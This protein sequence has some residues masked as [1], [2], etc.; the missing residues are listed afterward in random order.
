MT[1]FTVFRLLYMWL[2]I[3]EMRFIKKN[4]IKKMYKCYS[5]L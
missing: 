4:K 5:V 2:Y 1:D 3:K